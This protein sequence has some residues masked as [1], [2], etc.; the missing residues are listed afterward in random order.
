MVLDGFN[1]FASIPDFPIS[2]VDVAAALASRFGPA[3][4]W[5]FVDVETLTDIDAVALGDLW[6][7]T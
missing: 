4:R 5:L 3:D 7:S 2:G 6:C 1:M